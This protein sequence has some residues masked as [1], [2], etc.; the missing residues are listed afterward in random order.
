MKTAYYHATFGGMSDTVFYKNLD[1][2]RRGHKTRRYPDGLPVEPVNPAWREKLRSPIPDAEYVGST[3]SGSVAVHWWR[4]AK[5]TD[6]ET[7]EE[8]IAKMPNTPCETLQLSGEEERVHEL[9]PEITLDVC[10]GR[11][12]ISD[13]CIGVSARELCAAGFGGLRFEGDE[14]N[15]TVWVSRQKFFDISELCS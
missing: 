11:G 5:P 10:Y 8:K 7:S 3:T 14:Y 6:I 15:L 13:D 2:P 1:Q 9:D 12:G 4:T